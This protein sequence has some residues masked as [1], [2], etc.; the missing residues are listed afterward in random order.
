MGSVKAAEKTAGVPVLQSAGAVEAD[1]GAPR[2]RR[3]ALGRRSAPL[4]AGGAWPTFGKISEKTLS[5][6]RDGSHRPTRDKV[7]KVADALD[8][9]IEALLEGLRRSRARRPRLVFPADLDPGV[10]GVV[11]A[12]PELAAARAHRTTALGTTGAPIAGAAPPLRPHEAGLGPDVRRPGLS[13]MRSLEA[14]LE[15]TRSVSLVGDWRSGKSSVLLT[16]A[17]RARERGR[18]VFIVSGTAIRCSAHAFVEAIVDGS[19]AAR[20]WTTSPT[21]S[22]AG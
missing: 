6:W 19:A 20:C 18:E 21:R 16:W 12:A 5:R 2:T 15:H 13:L 7:E 17:Q 22:A 4:A 11:P 14:A 3:G 8:V 9:P 1:R 10:L